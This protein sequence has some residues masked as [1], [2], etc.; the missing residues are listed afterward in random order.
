MRYRPE[1][2]GLRAIAV[3]PVMFFHAGFTAFGGGYVGVD[4][5]FVISGY[6][7]T[8][9]ILSEK[10]AGTFSLA[11]FYERRAR[12][13]LPALFLVMAVSIP[14]AWLWLLP[15][16]LKDF[17]ASV[18][19]I[20]VFLSNWL[21]YKQS[22]YFDAD[23][24]SKPLLHTWSLAVEEQYYVLFPALIILLWKYSRKQILPVLMLLALASLAYA[25]HRVL[26]NPSAAFFFLPA[27][28]WELLAGA[29]LA[30]HMLRN[31]T[32]HQGSQ[33]VGIAGLAL[34]LY[35]V[36]GF[37]R[38]T[39]FPSLYTLVPV[40]GAM[41]VILG[42]SPHTYA[43]RLLGMKPLVAVGLI[44]YSA[45]LWHQPLF[46][47]ARH[48]SVGEPG[49]LT[50]LGLFAA[51]MALAY[52]SWRFV[53]KPFRNSSLVSR[54]TLIVFGTTVSSMFVALGGAGY[55]S[56]G[57]PERFDYV[58][59]AFPGY[60]LN[61]KKLQED[62]W[63]ILR[64]TM[65][66]NNAGKK[67]DEKDL[68]FSADENRIKVLIV[69]NSHSK[70]LFNLFALNAE[71]FQ[72]FEFAR[73]GAQIA[74]LGDSTNRFFASPNYR[75]ADVV[76]VSTRWEEARLCDGKTLGDIEGARKL[77][78]IAQQDGKL[79][80]IASNSLAF[81]AFGRM[82]YTDQAILSAAKRQSSLNGPAGRQTLMQEI[83]RAHFNLKDSS[84]DVGALNAR[85]LRFTSE[86]GLI[87]LEKREY[88]CDEPGKACFGINADFRKSFY[89]YGHYTIDGARTFGM[90]AHAI[91]WLD[92]VR[93]AMR[94]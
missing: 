91:G 76:L 41:L 69:G 75:A 73:Y 62:S 20:S 5:F 37:D 2:D 92:P 81:P 67:Y 8:S 19:S 52:L 46:V 72:E 43:G 66:G 26:V 18:A 57:K 21:F 56:N 25:Q 35:A 24:E 3:L 15:E 42:A 64:Q 16:D 29:L 31:R 80:V 14:F 33:L 68:W 34:I 77:A 87:Y 89:D 10:Q 94:R 78:S 27:R 23:A 63:K 9:I 40:A 47:Y 6:L 65:K 61:N 38:D 7:I 59:A 12:R 36:F 48:L 70:D 83:N 55:L 60:E 79:A 85:L 13:I 84:G 1:I 86:T 90:R 32:P 74:C 53:E 49:T 93:A 44:S 54:K 58:S 51:S 22:S 28:F 45:Y 4:V 88:L 30:F 39:P 82:T 17:S 11:N 50:M 71:L